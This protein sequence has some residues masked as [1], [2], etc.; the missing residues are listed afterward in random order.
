MSIITNLSFNS[1][2][3]NISTINNYRLNSYN[4]CSTGL[5]AGNLTAS[6]LAA[7]DFI[8]VGDGSFSNISTLHNTTI[9]SSSCNISDLFVNGSVSLQAGSL[10]V[11]NIINL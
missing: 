10:V 5:S 9:H 2:S 8:N 4:T 3:G 6:Y 7:K 11:S 1:S